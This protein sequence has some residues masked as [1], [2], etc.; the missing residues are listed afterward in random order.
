MCDKLNRMS[1]FKEICSGLPLDPLPPNRGRDPSVPH[2]PIRTPNLTAEEER[3]SK[4]TDNSDTLKSSSAIIC[5]SVIYVH[6]MNVKAQNKIF[7]FRTQ[8]TS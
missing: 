1:N 6:F 4:H 8:Q 3:V 2:A 5:T 7:I